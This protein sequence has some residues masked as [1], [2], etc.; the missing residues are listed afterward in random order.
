[1]RSSTFVLTLI[2]CAFIL[3]LLAG[4]N[5]ATKAPET[6]GVAKLAEQPIDVSLKTED[7]LTIKAT[8]YPNNESRK[9]LILIHQLNKDRSSYKQWAS[10][11]QKTRNVIAIDLRGHGE[12]DGDWQDFTAEEFNA[13]QLDVKATI[14]FLQRR[15]IAAQDTS[16]IGASIGANTAQNYASENLHDKII[17]L[18]PGL[19]YKGIVL[20]KKDNG[21]MIVVAKSDKYSYDSV[22]SLE[23]TM[24]SSEFIYINGG[25]HGTDML[26]ENIIAS[27][28]AF[29]D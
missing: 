6:G 27:I 18:S 19:E 13:M 21:A 4:C 11:L 3:V 12:S 25:K 10:E 22:K 7:G 1:M 16:I 24:K 26:D 20:D 14:D 8:F 28:K 15:N 2:I 5:E 9:G 29:L 17:L 23:S